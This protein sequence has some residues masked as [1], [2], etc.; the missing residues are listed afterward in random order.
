MGNAHSHRAGRLPGHHCTNVYTLV[1]TVINVTMT[2]MA[3]F[4]LSRKQFYG[5]RLFMF[6]FTITMLFEVG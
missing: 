5:R 6:L 1:G 2:V 3:G 4:P